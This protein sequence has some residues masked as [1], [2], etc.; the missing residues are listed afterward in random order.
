[1]DPT[2]EELVLVPN[3]GD[4]RDLPFTLTQEEWFAALRLARLGGYTSTDAAGINSRTTTHW[5]RKAV[6]VGLKRDETLAPDIKKKVEGIVAFCAGP[7]RSGFALER[8]WKRA[9]SRTNNTQA[10]AK[11]QRNDEYIRRRLGKCVFIPR[12]DEPIR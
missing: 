8:R 9:L 6:E 7:G 12:P 3:L 4:A 5:F 2:V 1:M 10:P 11:P